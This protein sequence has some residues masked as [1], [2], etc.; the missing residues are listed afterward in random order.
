MSIKHLKNRLMAAGQAALLALGCAFGTAHAADKWVLQA[1]VPA[2]NINLISI[3]VAQQACFFREEGLQVDIQYT[4]GA[5]LATQLVAS[6]KADVGIVS[7]EPY[8]LGYD[9]GIRGKFI[10]QT[11]DQ[12]IY[13]LAVSPDSDI[14]TAADLKGKKI[15]VSNMG[16]ASLVIAKSMVRRAG[17]GPNDVTFLPVGIGDT[18]M[19]AL[20]GGQ[21]QALSLWDAAYAG[22][23]R[24]GNKFRYIDHPDIAAFGNGGI[25]TSDKTLADKRPQLERFTRALAKANLFMLANPEQ[26]LQAYW[27]S[28]PAAKTGLDPATAVDKGMAEIRFKSPFFNRKKDEMFGTLDTVLYDKYQ[29]IM[30]EEGSVPELVP[31]SNFMDGSL[32]PA[33]NKLDRDAI[34]QKARGWT[35]AQACSS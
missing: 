3:Y 22:L 27:L 1:G 34:M 17:L 29:R 33:A 25:F 35:A 15:G 13:F 23:E 19:A 26:T 12:L 9:K 14:K 32:I 18:A 24:A 11:F 7:Y 20:R 21:I 16:S 10:Y 5:P 30:K 6:S 28:N 4:S 8:L 2:P 31:A